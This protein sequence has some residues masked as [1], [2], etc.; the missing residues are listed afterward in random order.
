MKVVPSRI[1]NLIY[2]IAE[3]FDYEVDELPGSVMYVLNPK[4][5]DTDYAEVEE[6]LK[7]V[8]GDSISF[9]E[10]AFNGLTVLVN[11]EELE[12]VYYE[13]TENPFKM[14]LHEAKEILK[15][16]GYLVEWTMEDANETFNLENFGEYL[17]EV[18]KILVNMGFDRGKQADNYDELHDIA[19]SYCAKGYK[20]EDCAKAIKNR[21]K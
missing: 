20:P 4:S 3:H 12:D 5:G 11:E 21:I 14:N 17:Y 13:N 15:K 7:R 9:D 10:E 2:E 6:E 1:E 16:N 18:R 19:L 8:L